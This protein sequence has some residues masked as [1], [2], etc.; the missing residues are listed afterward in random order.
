MKKI[1]P[2]TQIFIGMILAIIT[3]TLLKGHSDWATDY[4]K[5]FGTIFLNLIKLLVVPVTLLATIR[6]IISIKDPRTLKKLGIR[7]YL[8]S[9]LTNAEALVLGLCFGYICK[10]FFPVFSTSD[11]AWQSKSVSISEIIISAFPSNIITPL[12]KMAILPLVVIALLVGVSIRLAG[13]EAAPAERSIH[14]WYLVFMKSLGLV[15]IFAPIGVFGL[16]T[17]MVLTFGWNILSSL[18]VIFIGVYA[19][20]CFQLFIFYPAILKYFAQV[21]PVK[22]YKTYAPLMSFAF[23]TTSSTAAIPINLDCANRFGFP[24]EISSYV[25]PLNN[26]VNKDGTEIFIGFML[27]FFSHVFSIPVTPANVLTLFIIQTLLEFTPGIPGGILISMSILLPVAGLPIEGIAITASID[28]IFDMGRT[29]INVM[30]Y[31]VC[32]A[33]MSRFADN[34]K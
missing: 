8:Y 31:A 27:V 18:L 12:S 33:V 19:A 23:T 7:T 4:I 24:P 28:K 25:V 2:A 20:L 13:K 16:F 5:P 6:A 26:I 32:T 22:L 21:S 11:L 34:E 14:A 10:P 9:F 17:P 29:T 30:G 15:M 1:G 3:A